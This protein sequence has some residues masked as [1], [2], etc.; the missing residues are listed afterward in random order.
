MSQPGIDIDTVTVIQSIDLIHNFPVLL[1]R[2]CVCTCVC[3]HAHSSV[4]FVICAC[5]I[6]HHSQGAQQ[7]PSR[8]GSQVTL[9][10]PH[11]RPSCRLPPS[12]SL[13]TGSQWFVLRFSNLSFQKRY[14]CDNAAWNPGIGLCCSAV[15]PRGPHWRADRGLY[16]CTVSSVLAGGSSPKDPRA[17]ARPD[18]F[19]FLI[20]PDKLAWAFM[21]RVWQKLRFHF[22]GEVPRAEA[23]SV[24]GSPSGAAVELPEAEGRARACAR[25]WRPCHRVLVPFLCL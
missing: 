2:V 18:R 25:L 17:S 20:V 22:S 4:Q 23:G 16:L 11:S 14:L 21:W 7:F 24:S 19:W 5:C 3:V 12:S 15:T 6:H 8:E 10:K 1:A 13:S 9:L